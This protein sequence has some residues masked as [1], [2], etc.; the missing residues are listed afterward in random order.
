MTLISKYTDMF[1]LSGSDYS[2]RCPIEYLANKLSDHETHIYVYEFER[3]P[4]Q[5]SADAVDN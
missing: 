3:G 4:T 5:T 1:V 2:N